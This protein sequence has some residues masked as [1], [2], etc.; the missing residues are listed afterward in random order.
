[1]YHSLNSPNFSPNSMLFFP[2]VIPDNHQFFDNK[3]QQTTGDSSRVSVI[4]TTKTSHWFPCDRGND[5]RLQF[6]ALDL[7]DFDSVKQAAKEPGL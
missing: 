1:M 5:K 4:F 7:S 2:K 6:L 3:N